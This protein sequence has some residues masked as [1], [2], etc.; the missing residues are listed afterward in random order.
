MNSKRVI[1]VTND[2]ILM[3]YGERLMK[4]LMDRTENNHFLLPP[5]DAQGTLAM[6]KINED[7]VVQLKYV[8]EI[9]KHAIDKEGNLKKTKKIKIEAMWNAKLESGQVAIVNEDFV[10]NNFGEKFIEECKRLGDKCYVPIPV[11]SSQSSVISFVPNLHCAEAPRVQYQQG[12]QD[13]CV[14]SPLASALYYT[15]ISSLKDLANVLHQKLTKLSGGINSLVL[16]KEIVQKRAS[17]LMCKKVLLRFNWEKD[18]DE[19]M[20]LE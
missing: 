14:F 16:V 20:I 12:D 6:I 1:Q 7:K 8:P 19:N 3:T 4:K 11:R 17:W 9:Y 13:T 2:W 10:S 18:L 15:G 5:M